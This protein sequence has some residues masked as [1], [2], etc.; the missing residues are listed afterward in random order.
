L[1]KSPISDMDPTVHS[2]VLLKERVWNSR[3]K[4]GANRRKFLNPREVLFYGTAKPFMHTLTAS[5]ERL[6]LLKIVRM[7]T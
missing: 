1:K 3:L 2:P 6:T 7:E 4:M 5:D